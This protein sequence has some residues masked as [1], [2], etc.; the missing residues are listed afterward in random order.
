MLFFSRHGVG[1]SRLKSR[2]TGLAQ[3]GLTG[4]Q[5]GWRA[6]SWPRRIFGVSGRSRASAGAR[7]IWVISSKVVSVAE[8][9]SSKVVHS[10]M[11][12]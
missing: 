7:F 5:V 4:F 11:Q 6:F 12:G 2:Q 10:K 3:V 8:S 9:I 1:R